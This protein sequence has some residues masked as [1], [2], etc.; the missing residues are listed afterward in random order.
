MTRICYALYNTAMN[1]ASRNQVIK[2]LECDKI[3][4]D[5]IDDYLDY[6][7]V[8]DYDDFN[9]YTIEELGILIYTDNQIKKMLERNIELGIILLMPYHV[10]KIEIVDER[11]KL[12]FDMRIA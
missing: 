9:R 1:R 4:R 10:T 2:L 8:F 12:L 6:H 3:C 11:K 7:R 5:C